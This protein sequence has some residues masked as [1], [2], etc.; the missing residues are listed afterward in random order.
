MVR[1]LTETP[2]LFSAITQKSGLAVDVVLKDRRLLA[3][4]SL[5]D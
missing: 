3:T 2:G 4:H 1:I 5:L